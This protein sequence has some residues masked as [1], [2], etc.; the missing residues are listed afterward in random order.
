MVFL[1]VLQYPHYMRR[2]YCLSLLKFVL[3]HT[4]IAAAKTSR[5]LI[6]SIPLLYDLRQCLKGRCCCRLVLLAMAIVAWRHPIEVID[7]FFPLY[8]R[9]HEGIALET[10]SLEDLTINSLLSAFGFSILPHYLLEK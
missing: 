9:R 5:V 7:W 10:D 1:S 8:F 6:E 3:V 2:Q 4:P